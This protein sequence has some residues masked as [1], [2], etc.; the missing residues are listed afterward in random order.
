[1][2]NDV[3]RLLLR[4]KEGDQRAVEE[5]LPLIYDDLHRRAE[6]YM[7]RERA[8]H[9]LEPAILVHDAYL[10]LVREAEIT[11][12]DRDHFFALA[13]RLMRRA[14]I[15]HARRHAAGIRPD[16]RKRVPMKTAIKAVQ[17]T[18]TDLLALD[19]ALKS[20]AELDERKSRVVELRCFSGMSVQE[21]ARE[22][23]ITE[24]TVL[25]EWKVA[26]MFLLKEL[27]GRSGSG[28]Q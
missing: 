12:Q 28:G 25:R 5:L 26:R 17:E 10:K 6:A 4:V 1:M 27:T 22:L 20:L 11:W 8:G 2:G 14:L 3:T 15:D 21:V 24:R 19:D 23:G 13:A 7:K 18:F 16:S 9:T